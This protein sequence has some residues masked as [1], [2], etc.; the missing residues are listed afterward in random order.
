[1]PG[2][3]LRCS[4][5]FRTRTNKSKKVERKRGKKGTVD[6][7]EYIIASFVKMVT[8][9]EHLQSRS[10]QHHSLKTPSNIVISAEC[11]KVLPHLLVLS[12]EHKAECESLKSEL[13]QFETDLRAAIAE[14]WLE[15]EEEAAIEEPQKPKKPIIA[16]RNWAIDYIGV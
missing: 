1:M 6:E 11:S 10:C 16:T 4:P 15:V 13:Q 3:C 8:R 2:S 14:V 7:E 5:D 12:E 9:L